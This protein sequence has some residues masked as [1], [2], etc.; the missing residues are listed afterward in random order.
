MNNKYSLKIGENGSSI[1]IE[2]EGDANF[3]KKH[4]SLV[5]NILEGIKKNN[6]FSKKIDG[7]I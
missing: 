5:F 1:K 4:R 6:E 2:L 7:N 3:I